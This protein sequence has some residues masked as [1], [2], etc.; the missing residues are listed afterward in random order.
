MARAEIH[1]AAELSGDAARLETYLGNTYFVEGNLPP[2]VE[3]YRRAVEFDP[4]DP[5]LK[6]NLERAMR[7]LVAE[8]R[9]GNP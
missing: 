6:E 4:D 9:S 3:H 1:Q 5:G 2:A 7:K 8:E